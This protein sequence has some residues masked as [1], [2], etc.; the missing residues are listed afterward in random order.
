MRKQFVIRALAASGTAALLPCEA[1][2]SLPSVDVVSSAQTGASLTCNGTADGSGT[3]IAYAPPAVSASIPA[4]S[5]WRWALALVYGGLDIT[6][7]VTDCGQASRVALVNNWSG[8]FQN[9]CTNASA[10]GGVCSDATHTGAGDGTHAPLWHA[11]RPDDGS[12]AAQVFANLIGIATFIPASDTAVNG[13][14][15]SPYCNAINWDTNSENNGGTHCMLGGHD[16]WVGPGGVVD[17]SSNWRFNG[18]GVAETQIGGVGDGGVSGGGNHRR[19]PPNT[20]GDHID[21]NGNRVSSADVL[22]TSLQDNDPIRLPCVGTANSTT[23]SAENVCNLDRSLG[24]VLSVAESVFITN[25]AQNGSGD[26]GTVGN[27]YP[28]VACDNSWKLAK[29]PSVYNCAPFNIN[30]NHPSRHAGECPTGDLLYGANNQCMIPINVA[31]QTSA[32]LAKNSTFNPTVKNVFLPVPDGRVYNMHMFDG[33][34]V[35]GSI[36]YWQE[37]VATALA[38]TRD[39]VGG[40]GRIHQQNVVFTVLDG[41]QNA[42][43]QSD[44]SDQV[45]CLTQAD[46][47]SIGAASD[48]ATGQTGVG[49]VRVGGI[50]PTTSTV[51]GSYQLQCG[52]GQCSQ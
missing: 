10:E 23:G 37:P 32:C 39:F 52:A 26:A 3:G 22:S 27:Q 45:G 41:S 8:L 48:R 47:C 25:P 11:F 12:D 49:A 28:S 13:F 38:S 9:A 16:Q 42:C 24:L 14:G 29:A 44:W 19:P 21:P 33:D 18:F 15:T 17:P 6:T 2:A 50:E 31:N 5:Q 51:P 46:P 43:L 1:R 30:N 7:G 20:W 40:I 4:G 36:S 35:D 34:V